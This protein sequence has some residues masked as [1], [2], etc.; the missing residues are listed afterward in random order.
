MT[1]ESGSLASSCRRSPRSADWNL[2]SSS[3]SS[4]L[5]S[6]SSQKIGPSSEPFVFLARCSYSGQGSA[7]TSALG[8]WVRVHLKVVLDTRGGS[9]T[10]GPPPPTCVWRRGSLDVVGPPF[11]STAGLLPIKRVNWS[12][13]SGLPPAD[14]TVQ[15][16]SFSENEKVAECDGS[17]LMTSISHRF[18]GTRLANETV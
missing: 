5:Q 9:S 18:V 15:I 10:R 16:F 13:F 17:S 12:K 11:E 14:T 7:E 3:S 1:L 4:R 2:S 8:F 6:A